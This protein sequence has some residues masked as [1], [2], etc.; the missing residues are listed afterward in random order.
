MFAWVEKQIEKMLKPH[1][2]ENLYVHSN[3]DG[4]SLVSIAWNG[5]DKTDCASYEDH[6]LDAY[7]PESSEFIVDSINLSVA[8]KRLIFASPD[9]P[10]M[11]I[12]KRMGDPIH[13]QVHAYTFARTLA[14]DRAC[15]QKA[16]KNHRIFKERVMRFNET[17]KD[18]WR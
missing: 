15:T 12:P 16:V 2:H 9:G 6:V 7:E 1:F 11:W 3:D 8:D 13:F 18:R 5:Q 14:I 4:S 10:L 17:L